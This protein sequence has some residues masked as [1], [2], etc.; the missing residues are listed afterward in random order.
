MSLIGFLHTSDIHPPNFDR[1]TRDAASDR[2]AVGVSAR[3]DVRSDLLDL[4]LELGPDSP[5][6]RAQVANA[7]DELSQAGA[8]VVVCTCSTLA[9]IAESIDPN[10]I[11]IDRPMAAA[12]IAR[13]GP[14]AI[15]IA[16]ASTAG[17]TEALFA[18]GQAARGGEG[19]HNVVM[20]D[21]AW[22]LFEA[23][24]IAGYEQ[25]IA[26][27]ADSLNDRYKT[28]VL[29]Q[30]SMSSAAHRIRHH[31]QVMTSPAMCVATAVS[32]LS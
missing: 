25:S 17:P 26:D 13:G 27:T 1:L 14:T 2:G 24:D 28:I 7:L 19:E 18:Q 15:L 4:A 30:A 9:G 16:V 8:D 5:D 29:G 31:A 12:A 22:A 3:H 6:V 20:C 10:I 23:G 21:G 11:R 32:R